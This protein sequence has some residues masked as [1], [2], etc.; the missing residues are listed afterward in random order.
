MKKFLLSGMFLS[1]A[2]CSMGAEK[3]E[4]VS[5]LDTLVVTTQPSMRC[6]KCEN[7]IKSNVRFV[8]GT[9]SIETSLPDQTVTIIYDKRKATVS[10]FEK[11]FGRIGYE[12]RVLSGGK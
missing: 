9:K 6:M 5:N 8:K 4:N 10:D 12:I 7:K 2:L 11:E 1:L 3:N